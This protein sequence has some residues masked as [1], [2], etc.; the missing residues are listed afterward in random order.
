MIQAEHTILHLMT[1][2]APCPV[3]QY[4]ND[5]LIVT[6][7][8][9]GLVARLKLVLDTFAE[10]TGLKIYYGKSSVVPLHASPAELAHCIAIFQCKEESFPQSYLGL[11][12]S[13]DK[14]KLA[15]LMPTIGRA[16]K[17]LVGWKASLLN[18]MG[19]AVLCD[20][21][22]GNLLIYAMCAMELPKGALDLL[23]AKRR[24]FLWAGTDKA[25][26]AQCLIAWEKVCV[27]RVEMAGW[28]SNASLSKTNVCC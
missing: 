18:T 16:D 20:F 13:P 3:L 21:I 25:S 11:P 14:V 4:A 26:G 24:A 19:R 6:K 22:L 8:D 2:G 10:A 15:A 7:A 28:G 23:D 9:A 1:L 12:L 27:C 5:T 17:H